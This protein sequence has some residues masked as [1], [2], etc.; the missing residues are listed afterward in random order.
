ML[1]RQLLRRS[2]FAFARPVDGCGLA[3]A[4]PA[5]VARRRGD[6][7]RAAPNVAARAGADGCAVQAH[8]EAARGGGRQAVT[9]AGGTRCAAP[10]PGSFS[11]SGRFKVSNFKM[12]V[13]DWLC[14][15][16]STRA[17]PDAWAS[18][19]SLSALAY[20]NSCPGMVVMTNSRR[21]RSWLK[22]NT[23]FN[24]EFASTL[25]HRRVPAHR[26]LTPRM[27]VPL[28][29]TVGASPLH[30]RSL[31]ILTHSSS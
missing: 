21:P 13:V 18:C 25:E 24:H 15:A 5:L 11:Q 27:P 6:A 26:P 30:S 2:H 29:A 28:L 22:A 23:I 7:G 4:T 20:R 8:P 31:V 19:P 16:R 9:C 14:L 12:T 17:Q 3:A 10:S 1:L